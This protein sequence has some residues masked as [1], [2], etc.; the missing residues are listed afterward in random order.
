MR[1]SAIAALFALVAA[2]C[3]R[4]DNS[5]DTDQAGSNLRA[6][7]SAVAAQRS[8]LSADG[9]DV[10]H[11]KRALLKEQQELNDKEAALVAKARQ[12]GTAQG[13]L[14]EAGTAYRA[15][16]FERLAKLDAS[17]AALSTK[18]DAASTDAVV[19]LKA[20]RGLLAS[21]LGAMPAPGDAGWTAYTKDVDT[22][23]DAIE[24]DLHAR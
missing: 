10:E 21:R 6:A 3:G 8:K 11:R 13:T 5:A 18:T 23:F 16:V 19:G 22:T 4:T 20:R 1:A 24:R 14:T 2:A 12:L 9:D 17:L 7:Q 15:A